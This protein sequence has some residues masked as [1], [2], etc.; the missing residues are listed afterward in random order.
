L[1][2]LLLLGLF[3]LINAL[4]VR[5]ALPAYSFYDIRRITQLSLFLISSLMLL[6]SKSLREQGLSSFLHL[7]RTSRILLLGFFALGAISASLS[8]IPTFAFLDWATALM[9]VVLVF[10]F[11]AL[12]KSFNAHFDRILL[13]GLMLAIG[14]YSLIAIMTLLFIANHLSDIP[15]STNLF[16]VLSAPTFNNPRFLTDLMSWSLGL[17]VL[18]NLLYPSKSRLLRGALFTLA[19]YWWCL[20]FAGQSRALDLGSI[21]TAILL[22]TVFGKSAKQYLLNQILAVL[23]G[24]ALYF[25]LYHWLISLPLRHLSLL[26]PDNRLQIWAVALHLIKSHP[27][28]GVGPLHF[29]YYAYSY[30]QLVAHPHNGIL[31]LAC[32][33]GIPAALMMVSLIFMGLWRW[34]GFAKEQAKSQANANLYIGLSASLLMAGFDSM[35]SGTLVMPLSQVM[36]SLIVGWALSLYFSNRTTLPVTQYLH[37]GLIALLIIALILLA[38]GIL[39]VIAKLPQMEV[40]YTVSC[41]EQICVNSP[42]YWLQG[43][44]QLY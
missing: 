25:I 26:D 32:E 12:R 44:I 10:H 16:Y 41:A 15:A 30:E 33:W 18:P 20:G 9:I 43:W 38:L 14:C 11:A 22:I 36:L 2:G 6:S 4:T 21:A 5:W 28:L 40:N 23:G 39:P 7:P 24:I 8:A 27:L 17:V 37:I 1:F 42:N 13:Y 19:A 35:F 31:L 34:I 3:V 29:P